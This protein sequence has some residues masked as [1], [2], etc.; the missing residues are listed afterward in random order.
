MCPG[1]RLSMCVVAWWLFSFARPLAAFRDVGADV[2][3]EISAFLEH[4]GLARDS[5]SIPVFGASDGHE[6]TVGSA[7]PPDLTRVKKKEQNLWRL[8]LAGT[9]MALPLEVAAT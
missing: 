5:P 6:G 2:Q 3:G 4:N 7:P 9:G 1:G 8:F